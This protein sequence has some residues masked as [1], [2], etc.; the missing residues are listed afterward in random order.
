MYV[1]QEITTYTICF[2]TTT[3]VYYIKKRAR[4]KFNCRNLQ[5]YWAFWATY[6]LKNVRKIIK[7][8]TIALNVKLKVLT[9]G[10]IAVESSNEL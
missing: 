3:I 10:I 1:F 9:K 2:N 6:L 5:Y 4:V 7:S 8:R